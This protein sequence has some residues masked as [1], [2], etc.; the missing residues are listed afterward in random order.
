MSHIRKETTSSQKRDTLQTNSPGLRAGR[1][2]Q[3][4]IDTDTMF[5]RPKLLRMRVPRRLFYARP[6]NG[7]HG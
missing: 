2:I 7:S 5:D 4:Q 1:E 6:S 3:D